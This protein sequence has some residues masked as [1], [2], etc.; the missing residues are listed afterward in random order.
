M[1]AVIE[2]SATPAFTGRKSGVNHGSNRNR[3]LC[4]YFLFKCSVIKT[5]VT[6]RLRK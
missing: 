6:G 3:Y 2:S 5:P 1:M 4:D